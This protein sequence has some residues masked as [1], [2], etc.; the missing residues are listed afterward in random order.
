[1]AHA[2]HAVSH[3]MK[4]SA[5]SNTRAVTRTHLARVAP[6]HVSGALA[7]DLLAV[8][9]LRMQCRVARTARAAYD[10]A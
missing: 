7:M 9:V 2:T 10:L 8:S 5:G 1:M 3:A 6:A 4:G